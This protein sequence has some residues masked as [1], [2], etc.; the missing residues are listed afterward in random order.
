MSAKPGN[1]LGELSEQI[2]DMGNELINRA[3][4]IAASSKNFCTNISIH[5]YFP[6]DG[7]TIPTIEW[8]TECVSKN[9]LDRIREWRS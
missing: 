4:D 6:Q 3:D 5:I 2:K 8:T 9:M 1:F 7:K